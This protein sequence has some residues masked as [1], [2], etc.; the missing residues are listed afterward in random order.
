MAPPGTIHR[1]I[2]SYLSAAD[3][4]LPGFKASP[5]PGPAHLPAW[6]TIRPAWEIAAS[7]VAVPLSDPPAR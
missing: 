5:E 1:D 2:E 3:G 6:I 4:A 7:R